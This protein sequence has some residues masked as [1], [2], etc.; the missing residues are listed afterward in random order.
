MLFLCCPHDP[1]MDCGEKPSDGM[2]GEGVVGNIGIKTA[3]EAAIKLSP[4]TFLKL[5]NKEKALAM[6]TAGLS[7]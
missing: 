2:T 1:D 4:E 7:H 3:M 5:H 6:T